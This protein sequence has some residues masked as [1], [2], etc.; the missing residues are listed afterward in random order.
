MSNAW[1]KLYRQ[2]KKYLRFNLHVT[3]PFLQGTLSLWHRSYAG[4]RL[5]DCDSLRAGPKMEMVAYQERIYHTV[6]AEKNKLK[7]AWLQVRQLQKHLF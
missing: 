1:R 6:E 5:V 3:N 2:A 7:G 4:L